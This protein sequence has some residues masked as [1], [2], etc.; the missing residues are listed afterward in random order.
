MRPSAVRAQ[1]LLFDAVLSVVWKALDRY[2]LSIADREDLMERALGR[3][4]PDER[5]VVQLVEIDDLTFREVAARERIS[6]ST[7]YHR[8]R[9]GLSALRDVEA[10]G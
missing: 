1:K 7:A 8:H 6:P 9:R 10:G 4:L 2:A 5:R 3:L